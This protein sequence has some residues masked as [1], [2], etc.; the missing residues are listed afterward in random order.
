MIVKLFALIT[1]LSIQLLLKV[2]MFTLEE[3]QEFR[4]KTKNL[5]RNTGSLVE[6]ETAW[7]TFMNT[8]LI[9]MVVH[10]HQIIKM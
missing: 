9:R 4:L 5:L 7:L 2:Q 8:L 3:W 10:K 6:A 1:P